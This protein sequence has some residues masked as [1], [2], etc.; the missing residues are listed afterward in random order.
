MQVLE[1]L[2]ELLHKSSV[3]NP[4]SQSKPTCILWP[5]KELQFTS[6][7]ETLQAELP[8]L[9]VLGDYAPEKR[10]GP[11]IWL[12]CVLADTIKETELPQDSIPILYLP[13]VGR[14]DLRAV[15]SCPEHL[16]PLAELQYRGVIW[17]QINSKDWTILSLLKSDQGGFALDVSQDASTKEAMKLALSNLLEEEVSLLQGKRLDK[18]YFNS[19]LSGGDPIKGLL[20]WLNEGESYVQKRSENEWNAFNQ[21]SKSQ[22]GFT[23]KS[24]GLLAAAENL[25]LHNGV[26]LSIWERYCESP[27]RYKNIPTQIRNCKM[28]SFDLFADVSEK[29]KWPQWND[30]E[31]VRLLQ[32]LSSLSEKPAHIA[33]E[34]ILTLEKEHGVRR[35]LI[36]TELGDSQLAQVLLHLSELAK[37]TTNSLAAGNIDD[38]FTSYT[39]VGWKA[40]D[41]VLKALSLTEVKYFEAVS[42]AIRAIYLPWAEDNAIYLQNIVS[43]S[44]YPGKTIETASSTSYKDGECVLFVDGLRFDTAK[45]LSSLLQNIGLKPKETAY[46]NPLPSVTATGKPSVAPVRD[47]IKGIEENENFEPSVKQTGQSLKGGYHLKKLL[48]DDGWKILDRNDNG[49]GVGNAWCEFGDIDH[50]GH[51]RGWKLA[52][53]VDSLLE[54]IKERIEELLA[55]GWKEVRIVTDHGWLL[56]P[57]GLSKIELPSTLTNS[58]WGRCAV[59]KSGAETDEKTFPWY[60]NSNQHFALAN[61]ISCFKKGDEY[62]HGGLSVQECIVLEM[63]VCNNSVG[64][65]KS[66]VELTDIVWRNLRC[67]IAADGD[68]DGLIVDIRLEAG[69]KDSSV[70]LSTKN[71]SENGTASV[72]VEDEDSQGT[73]AFVV[74][75]DSNGN[76]L[77]QATTIIGGE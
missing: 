22:F 6:I 77:N 26:W 65:S 37:I 57:Q 62:N 41:A 69:N 24:E 14:Q 52:K 20:T 16:K 34:N 30:D 43:E 3:Y 70:V 72:V 48:R 49:D 9:F 74:I 31:E 28:P 61:G 13:G 54:E 12:R 27:K 5:D 25:A 36:W 42:I 10:T 19:L 39:T 63:T 50:E 1:K 75:L 11:A 66:T 71:L 53:H 67:K 64:I 32:S 45:R 15:E 40:D 38:I 35:E 2:I 59:L 68:F 18:D 76:I 23:P 7:I 58:K 17:S 44:S 60:W 51:D 47:K 46:W 8:E 56:M 33:R 21:V 29:G 73:Q 55:A 4:D